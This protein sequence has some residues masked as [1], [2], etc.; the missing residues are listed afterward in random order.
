MLHDLGFPQ[1]LVPVF[2]DNKAAI[3]LTYRMN[4]THR[5]R[6][7]RIRDLWVRELVRTDLCRILYC[8][9]LQQLADFFTK[10]LS[11]AFYRRIVPILSGYTDSLHSA[12]DIT[13]SLNDNTPDD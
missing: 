2:E 12:P 5:T 9:T 13:G 10:I 6:H 3:T 11:P 7:M 4:V 8:S 1:R